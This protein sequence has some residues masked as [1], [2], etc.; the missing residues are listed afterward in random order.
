DQR[1]GLADDVV[2]PDDVDVE[3]VVR[4]HR[5]HRRRVPDQREVDVARGVGLHDLAAG[6]ELG[7]RDLRVRHARLEQAE[8]LDDE[9]AVRDALPADRDLGL[10]GG[11]GLPRAL[12]DGRVPGLGAT[13]VDAP[14]GGE[15]DRG[16][17]RDSGGATMVDRGHR[18]SSGTDGWARG[19]PHALPRKGIRTF[20]TVLTSWSSRIAV[21]PMMMMQAM[22]T[23]VWF[24][25]PEM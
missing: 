1:L 2:D 17:Q 21:M 4:R 8:V 22:T 19:G 24:C 16:E 14:G 25:A 18:P 5:E 7:P 12:V 11:V 6:V 20:S 9:V 3:V 13:A 10:D 15:R 23:A